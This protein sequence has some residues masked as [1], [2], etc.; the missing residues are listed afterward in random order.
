[1]KKKKFVSFKL[2][3]IQ[4]VSC[5]IVIVYLC[6]LNVTQVTRFHR[7]RTDASFFKIFVKQETNRDNVCHVLLATNW[8]I[9][10]AWLL[11]PK[12]QKLKTKFYRL[13]FATF[14]TLQT[15]NCAINAYGATWKGR[16]NVLNW[17]I[18]VRFSK[19]KTHR[20]SA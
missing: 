11:P 4:T 8:L 9:T 6:V 14:R 7:K 19:M 16:A 10:Y 1:M 3:Q 12:A 2:P 18:N 20:W 13:K 15:K 5:L 17:T